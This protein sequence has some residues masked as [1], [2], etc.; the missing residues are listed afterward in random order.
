M[1]PEKMKIDDIDCVR[2]NKHTAKKAY[3]YGLIV[4]VYG[5]LANPNCVWVSPSLW[6]AVGEMIENTNEEFEK[7]ENE[8][9]AY[10]RDL[11]RYGLKYFISETGNKKVY[12]SRENE[13]LEYQKAWY[14]KNRTSNKCRF[15]DLECECNIGGTCMVESY[16]KDKLT[17]N[18]ACGDNYFK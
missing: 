7:L 4:Y 5:D 14:K 3:K 12:Y 11:I 10:N 16:N 2:V 17:Y 8:F 1:I 13:R 6:I 9:R 18:T 15:L